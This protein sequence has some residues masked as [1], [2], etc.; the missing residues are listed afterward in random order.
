MTLKI[1]D[2][3]AIEANLLYGKAAREGFRSVRYYIRCGEI[4]ARKKAE[5]KHGE[6]L[7][8]CE[9]NLEFGI[10]TVSYC[11]KFYLNQELLAQNQPSSINEALHLLRSRKRRQSEDEL[12]NVRGNRLLVEI[13]EIREACERLPQ[14]PLLSAEERKLKSEMVKE[15]YKLGDCLG[16]TTPEMSL[17][18]PKVG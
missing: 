8:W 17:V 7:P 14:E 15:W 11:I 6:W 4:L 12:V 18:R 9:A 10:T 5:L 3:E 2:P 1:S 13:R 16:E